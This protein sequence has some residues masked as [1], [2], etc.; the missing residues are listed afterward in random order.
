MQTETRLVCG[1]NTLRGL[2]AICV[3]LCHFGPPLPI[4]IDKYT[5]LNIGYRAIRAFLY[6]LMNGQA[7]VI[8]FFII[9][10]FCIH[11]PQIKSLRIGHLRQY[12]IKRLVRILVPLGVGIA[13]SA[14]VGVCGLD[15]DNSV[16]W[17][18][19]CEIF[20]YF[21]YP[22]VLVIRKKLG[23]WLIIL[24]VAFF[25][26]FLVVFLSD[27]PISQAKLYQSYG[28]KLTWIVGF[29]CWLLGCV[30]SEYINN[31]VKVSFKKIYLIRI[32]CWFISIL[33]TIA[34]KH[35]ILGHPITLTIFSIPASCWLLNEIWWC[36]ERGSFVFLEWLGTWSYSIYLMHFPV[37]FFLI[38]ISTLLQIYF[39]QIL[40]WLFITILTLAVC[41][42]FYL[43]VEMP[44]HSLA[45]A[46]AKRV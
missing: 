3:L 12:Y 13:C 43:V 7:A 27:I 33:S 30:I 5:W 15:F 20:F 44:S 17:S 31:P 34:F 11:L 36:R 23:S 21:L 14:F 19:V 26:S 4:V 6:S 42:M 39:S 1:I 22:V 35:D 32:F 10:G 37:H 40:C 46:L 25:C 28:W 2:C 16:L 41:Y 24:A 9:S 38:V 18:L 45:R 29:P 8:I